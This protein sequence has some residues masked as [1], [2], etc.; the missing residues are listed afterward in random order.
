MGET[1]K[2][3]ELPFEIAPR[4]EIAVKIERLMKVLESSFKNLRGKKEE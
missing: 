1:G 4:F 2:S 3:I